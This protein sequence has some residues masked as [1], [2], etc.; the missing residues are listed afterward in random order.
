MPSSALGVDQLPVGTRC[1]DQN[2][3]LVGDSQGDA[4]RVGQLVGEA[5]ER[6]QVVHRGHDADDLAV[7]RSPDGRGHR[8]HEVIATDSG[9]VCLRD[10]WAIGHQRTAIPVAIAEI[11]ADD[12]GSH[13]HDVAQSPP[14]IGDEGAGEAGVRILQLDD[15]LS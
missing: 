10:V 7:P 13:G 8:H 9:L 6:L 1:S 14:R 11:L 15:V 4:L 2:P 3:T 12:L 5:L